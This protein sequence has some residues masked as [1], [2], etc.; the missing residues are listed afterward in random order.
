M[1]ITVAKS[2]GFCSGVRRALTIALTTAR[3]NKR[4]QMLGDIVHNEDV[5]K[6]I[7][8]TGIRKILRLQKGTDKILLIRAH[9]APKKIFE[10]AQQHGYTIIDATCPMVKEIHKIA[11][12]AEQKRCRVFIIGDKKHDEV[13]GIIGNLRKKA[14]V[15][16]APASIPRK[17]IIGIKEARVV[18]QS[19]QNIDNVIAIVEALKKTIPHVTFFNTICNPTRIKQKEARSM[20]LQNDAMIIVGSK[21]SANT[22]RLYEISKMLNKKSFWIQSKQD[23]KPQWFKG[24]KTVGVTSGASTPD[25]TTE[26][27]IKRIKQLTKK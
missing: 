1:K 27:V 24:I 23:I 19:T 9:G 17:K 4:V 15:I 2:A 16:D 8:Q 25:S 21:T 13:K 26:K 11:Q 12:Q 7:K 6:T 14:I 22:K 20:P 10:R 3:E 18:V 5:V